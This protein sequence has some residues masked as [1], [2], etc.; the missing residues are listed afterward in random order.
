M[1]QASTVQ[2]HWA[3]NTHTPTLLSAEA[4]Y[5]AAKQESWEVADDLDAEQEVPEPID[6]RPEDWAT[7]ERD[8]EQAQYDLEGLF[9]E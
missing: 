4:E 7:F 9:L 6:D 2:P 8:I 5:C 1:T 3:G